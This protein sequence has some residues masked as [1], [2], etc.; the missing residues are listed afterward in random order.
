MSPFAHLIGS[1]LVASVTTNNPRDRKLVTLAGVLPD[2][3]GL[4]AANYSKVRVH[5]PNKLDGKANVVFCDGHV[6]S[7][8][9]KFLFEDIS[10]T[11]S[12]R[13]KS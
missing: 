10:D 2:V 5:V 4:G 3:D 11:A 9:L 13:W 12:A 6:E 7:P 1:W 8:T